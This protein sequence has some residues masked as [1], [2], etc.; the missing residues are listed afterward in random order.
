MTYVQFDPR[1]IAYIMNFV[2]NDRLRTVHV[3]HDDKQ[4]VKI[5]IQ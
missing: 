1:T 3:V 4:T 5:D 2:H